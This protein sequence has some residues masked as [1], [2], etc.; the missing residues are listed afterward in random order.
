M[1]PY[2]AEEIQHLKKMK[3]QGATIKEIANALERSYWS[4]VYKWKEVKGE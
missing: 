1:R 2:S 4:N 3:Q